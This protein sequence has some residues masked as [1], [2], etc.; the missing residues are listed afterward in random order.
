[1][2][3]AKGEAAIARYETGLR[4]PGGSAPD[5]PIDLDRLMALSSGDGLSGLLD[6]LDAAGDLPAIWLFLD[7]PDR[8]LPRTLAAF[9]IARHLAERGRRVIVL[10]GDDQSA[11]LGGWA[12]RDTGEGWI[13]MVRYGTSL[14]VSSL[15]LSF[16]GAPVRLVP[17]GSYRPTRLSEGEAGELASK[18]DV[19]CDHLLICASAGESAALWAG[20]DAVAFACRGN[21]QLEDP[22]TRVLLKEIRLL[23]LPLRGLL[24]YE[25]VAETLP[26]KASAAAARPRPDRP[27]QGSSGIFRIAAGVLG[28]AIAA[29]AIWWFGLMSGGGDEPVVTDLEPTGDAVATPVS[30]GGDPV[31]GPTVDPGS[32]PVDD[33]APSSAM[34]EP[35]P[36]ETASDAG[37]DT[38]PADPFAA[39]VGEAGFC[40]HVYS[41]YT[42]AEAEAQ[43]TEMQGMGFAATIRIAV[44]DGHPW[45]RIYTGS[46]PTRAACLEARPELYER[47]GT[48]WA[49]PAAAADPQD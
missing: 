42:Q 37:P 17:V 27:R 15:E 28:V 1:M 23:D 20:L 9:S 13:D 22:D 11:H 24:T 6:D 38:G 16:D 44:V 2:A 32:E 25:R 39:P 40:L 47:L 18:L 46:F 4:C 41:C 31:D 34:S 49:A 3:A 43:I 29:L 10:D 30:S 48:D 45:R 19:Y 35:P 5:A 7:D 26:S 21:D 8:P 33:G 36:D 12:D 14:S